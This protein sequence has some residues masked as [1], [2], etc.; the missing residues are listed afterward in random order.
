M[1]ARTAYINY[2]KLSVAYDLL[3]NSFDIMMDGRGT[4][5][6]KAR[7][8]SMENLRGETYV[9]QDFGMPTVSKA[10]CAVSG[11]D[12]D[13]ASMQI[14]YSGQSIT[15]QD[16]TLEFL[17]NNAGVTIRVGGGGDMQAH[18]EGALH[19]GGQDQRQTMAVC[20]DRTGT[21]LR[22][23]SGPACSALDNALFDPDTDT[24]L[25]LETLSRVRLR[26]DWQEGNYRFAF[27]VP[28]KDYGRLLHLRVR[29]H[30]YEDLFGI[31][32]RKRNPDTTFK[33]P[34]TGWMTWYAVQFAASE[35]TV[36]ANAAVQRDKLKAYGA[37]A[38]WVDWEWYHRNHCGIGDAG[39]D[40][41][42]PDPAAYPNGLKAVADKIRAMG[43]T[44]ALWIGPTCDP[45]MN[46]M[47]K[48]HPESVMLH[49][50]M[51]CGQ[52]FW[53]PTSPTFLTEALPE[54][55]RH[56]F[57][58]GYDA[59]KWD[60]MPDTTRLLD[61]CY[62]TRVQQI[63]SR[64]AML[65]AYRKAREIAG[66]D[67]YMLFCCAL[68]QRD[69]DLACA[70]FDAARIGGDI[71]AWNDFLRECVG[72]VYKYYALHN[73]VLLADPDNV[74]LRPQFNDKE[75]AITRASLV[76]L[77]G[78]PFNIGDDLTQLDEDRM[79]IL[80]RS[81]PPI[82]NVRTMDLRSATADSRSMLINL[83]VERPFGRW[84][85][86]DV[87]N[88]SGEERLMR[89]DLW[90]DLHLEPDTGPYFVYDYWQNTCLGE[91]DGEFALQM[92]P[93]ASRILSVRPKEDT[94]VVLSTSRHIAHGAFDLLDVAWNPNTCVLSGQSNVVGK[95]PYSLVVSE[96][97]CGLTPVPG[98][99]VVSIGSGVFRV[100][101]Y[102]QQDGTFSWS[103][104]YHRK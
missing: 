32:Y 48:R 82:P 61:E 51:W 28:G 6:R 86:V 80:R 99:N 64:E 96:G 98:D 35:E 3:E 50:P 57:E 69:I 84:N 44:P 63:S 1:A 38:I 15:R 11:G 19:W 45:T 94:P 43:F 66:K 24:A 97:T 4:V 34:P 55:I 12:A 21:D 31:D 52:Y 79:E 39:V 7:V 103:I 53:D 93:F 23:A 8:T 18:I 77:L 70:A 68:S 26:Y 14:C 59:I 76:S 75:Q 33:T 16:F 91:I 62:E 56:V 10:G 20:L 92:P 37:N 73:V 42:H 90:S 89:V 78:M 72:K 104:A 2:K 30:V 27:H 58:W 29:R 85:V 25:V 88:L 47:M 36:L 101:F 60:C 83:C 5:V 13:A 100:T 17:L 9:L 49:R 95:E 67:T 102:P 54:T 65:G 46:E 41:F 40:M 74:I 22:C 81:I 71:F 87:A